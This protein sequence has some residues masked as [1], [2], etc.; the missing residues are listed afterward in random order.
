M[1]INYGADYEYFTNNIATLN[2]VAAIDST[3]FIAV[4]A[5][6]LSTPKSGSVFGTISGSSI[7]YATPVSFE[8]AD[9]SG[10]EAGLSVAMLDST[11]FVVAYRLASN[12]HGKA[13][14]GTISAGVISYGTV[15]EFYASDCY[16]VCVTAL[17]ATHFAIGYANS[18]S[19]GAYAII[20]TVSSGNVIGYGTAVFC[21]NATIATVNRTVVVCTLDATH[22]AIGAQDNADGKEYTYIGVVSSGN[23]ITFGSAYVASANTGARSSMVG[24]DSTHFVYYNYYDGAVIGVLSSGNVITY[25]SF[26]NPTAMTPNYD[27]LAKLDATH[28]VA[29]YTSV[30]LSKSALGTVSSGNV[31]NFATEVAWDTVQNAWCGASGLDANNFVIVFG[32]D[33]NNTH[34][35]GK[36]GYLPSAPTVTTQAVSSVASTTATGNGNV[37]A[38]GG[39]TITERGTV[40][41]TSANPTTAD[42]KDIATGTTGVFTTSIDTL[43][44]GTTYHVRAYAINSIGTSYGS[45]VSFKTLYAPLVAAVGVFTLTG[46]AINILKK[47]TQ[48]FGTASFV[49]TGISANFFKGLKATL[50][51]GI[52]ILTGLGV[53]FIRHIGYLVQLIVGQFTLTGNNINIRQVLHMMLNAGS[54]VLSGVNM[55]IIRGH[56]M[57]LATGTF[58]LTGINA[59]FHKSK[60]AIL[61]AGSFVLTGIDILIHIAYHRA[62]ATGVF[63]LTGINA[64]ISRSIKSIL[65]TGVFILTGIAMLTKYARRLVTRTGSFILTGL[66]ILIKGEGEWR[67]QKLVASVTSFANKVID[68]S[69]WVNKDRF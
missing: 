65:G 13:V 44:A 35:T 30:N 68:S 10:N 11:H 69:S 7:S 39:A 43:T 66:S 47:I 58:I 27:G 40:Y 61:V 46:I 37:T 29:V 67:F 33:N 38:D 25:G 14:I 19:A 63:I 34:G 36:I 23:V 20:G 53:T 64:I 15:Y 24:L 26:V 50:G 49:V 54:F 41:S 18:A 5:T 6:P 60:Y 17:D 3:H 1:A 57:V 52:F 8:S 56:H 51:T 28:F 55:I 16:N 62:L 9:I 4:Y 59:L 22:F 2:A 31:I 32:N 12:S 45:D 42:T 21:R 48:S